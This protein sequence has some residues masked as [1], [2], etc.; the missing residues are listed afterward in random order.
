MSTLDSEK[1]SNGTVDYTNEKQVATLQNEAINEEHTAEHSVNSTT[2]PPR[3]IDGGYGWVCVVCSLLINAH[4]WGI[5]ASYGVFLSYYVAHNTFESSYA[6][7]GGLTLCQAVLTAP[8]AT[9]LVRR[10]GTRSSLFTGIFFQTLGLISASFAKKDYQIILSQGVA[11][12]WGIGFLFVGN[13]AIISQ[14]FEKKRSFAN[15][16]VSSGVGFGALIYSL[17]SQKML[18]TIGLSWAFRVLAIVQFAVNLIASLLLRDRNKEIGSTH[19]AFSLGLMKRPEFLCLQVWSFLTTVGY[20]A[21]AFSVSPQAVSVGLSADKAALLNALYN[22]GQAIGRPTIGLISDKVGRITIALFSTVLSAIICYTFWLPSAY[23]S[24]KFGLLVFFN[25]TAGMVTG[26]FWCTIAAVTTE[27]VGLRELP[28][29]L[30]KFINTGSCRSKVCYKVLTLTLLAARY[31]MAHNCAVHHVRRTNGLSNPSIRF[32]HSFL[33]CPDFHR[34]HVRRRD[35]TDAIA[36][37]LENR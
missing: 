10:F 25:I 22:L 3:Q 12:G 30:S 20:T 4:T 8:V 35:N 19:R 5:V 2:T 13:V 24:S 34:I 28:S 37:K 26:V 17:A 29:A 1:Q 18:Q 31:D 33:S 36:A 9:F 27:V 6:Y 11:A 23:V 14:W 7:V 16:I 21:L 32:R 15:A